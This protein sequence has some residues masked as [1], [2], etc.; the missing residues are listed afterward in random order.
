MQ[1]ARPQEM[2]P[3]APLQSLFND[4][5][6]GQGRLSDAVLVIPGK[7]MDQQTIGQIIEDLSVMSRIIAKNALGEYQGGSA[8]GSSV[9][10]AWS[11]NSG[12]AGLGPAVLFPTP[13]RP[14]PMYLGG[15]GAVF[16]IEI[17]YPLL[18]PQ[19]PPEQSAGQQEDSVWAQAKHDVLEPRTYAVLP[20]EP[21]EPAE[22]Y[23]HEQVDTLRSQLIATM[24]H[25]TNIRV[26]EPGEW[27]V[28]VVQGPAAVPQASQNPPG[29]TTVTAPQAAATVAGKTVLTLRATKADVDQYAKGQLNQQQFEQ[30]LQIITY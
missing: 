28:V 8:F 23:S 5:G 7:P 27:V 25:A 17:S 14:K 26:L 13:D 10:F 1:E 15:Y 3:E 6:A 24:K 21:T 18:P 22:P 29:G 9:D 16:F 11:S 2:A 19:R 30:R 20:Q 4:L 12:S